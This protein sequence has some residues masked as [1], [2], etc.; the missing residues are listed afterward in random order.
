MLTELKWLKLWSCHT[1]QLNSVRGVERLEIFNCQHFSCIQIDY[2]FQIRAMNKAGKIVFS[3][4]GVIKASFRQAQTL[5]I[6]VGPMRKLHRLWAVRYDVRIR[7][8][9]HEK[10]TNNVLFFSS[11]AISI[12]YFLERDAIYAVNLNI[13]IAMYCTRT[14]TKHLG[15]WNFFPNRFSSF[16]KNEKNCLRRT[17]PKRSTMLLTDVD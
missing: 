3:S 9:G 11:F 1:Y 8:R 14:P 6:A 5:L 13:P 15:R 17:R 7:R 10:W 12:S 4:H 2:I 16:A